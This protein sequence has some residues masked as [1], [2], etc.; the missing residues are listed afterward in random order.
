MTLLVGAS[1]LAATGAYSQGA[2][3]VT[4]NGSM[5][6][7]VTDNFSRGTAT[8]AYFLNANNGS[9]YELQFSG[10][11]PANLD[12]YQP[13]IVTGW[14]DGNTLSVDTLVPDPDNVVMPP[15]DDWRKVLILLVDLQDARASDSYPRQQIEGL[16]YTNPRSVA[17]LF[18]QASLGRVDFSTGSNF[19]AVTIPYSTADCNYRAW[20]QAAEAAARQAGIIVNDYRHRLFVLPPETFPACSWTGAATLGC[21][22]QCRAWIAAGDQPIVYVHELG[23]NLNL[24]HAGTDLDNNG[25]IDSLDDLSDPMSLSFAPGWRS[26]N[27]PHVHQ[28]GWYAQYFNSI[29]SVA[30]SG[31]YIL[32]ALDPNAMNS[33]PGLP[34]MLKLAKPGTEDYYYLSYRRPTGYDTD[35]LETY[36]QGVNIN[37]YRGHGNSATALVGTLTDGNAAMLTDTSGGSI[38]V[39]QTGHSSDHDQVTVNVSLCTSVPPSVTLSPSS[40][41]VRPGGTGG[42]SV[43]V[44]N[45]DSPD[46]PATTFA[47]TYSGSPTG[48]ITPGSLNLNSRGGGNS[49]NLE[50]NAPAGLSSGIYPIEVQISD[51]DNVPP[52]HPV[53]RKLSG[54]FIV[55]GDPP[56]IPSG[57]S[58]FGNAQ[59]RTILLIWNASTDTLAGVQNYIIRRNNIE[60]GRTAGSN[61]T[62]STAPPGQSVYTVAA[63]D[64]AGNE[65]APS[66]PITLTW[67]TAPVVTITAP[68]DGTTVTTDQSI[69]FTGTATDAQDGNLTAGLSWTSSIDGTIGNGGA[70][71]RTLSAG[72]HTIQAQVLDSN[73][74]TNTATLTL[75]VATTVTFTS[76]GGE[77]GWVLESSETSNIGGSSRASD[78]TNKGLLLGDNN[79]N[80]QYKSILSFDTSA[81]P[82]NATIL[83]ATLRLQ[84]GAISGTN[85]FQTHGNLLADIK[86]GA[87]HNDPMLENVDFQSPATAV[88]V[89]TLSN[90]AFNGAWSEGAIDAN[91]LAAIDKSGRTQFRLYFSLDDNNDR[92]EDLLGY[93]AGKCGTASSRPQLVV[94]YR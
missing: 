78:N 46:C 5:E 43:G 47:L 14:L 15:P 21:G 80:R 19:V 2:G 28:M 24:N 16:M 20:A 55:D 9:T 1:L 50:V 48:T 7:L 87:F 94:I 88:G 56:T 86:N 75:Y 68:T 37:W 85:P 38:Q 18:S 82:D 22:Y 83:S 4:V 39:T 74:A 30:Q 29:V 63:I 53:S 33:S 93:Y 40:R 6:I 17:G 79:N 84:R 60:I 69:T 73:G 23:H 92:D 61:F 10:N 59:N 25:V 36:T 8:T 49:A 13:V 72:V 32:A 58:G 66:T 65:S 52:G 41:A 57:L 31:T 77:D 67:N 91:G 70:F 62:D 12:I 34:R 26:F 45:L 3:P 27:G 90:A 11:P 51:A 89:A 81:L 76:I 71:S 54:T 64:A 35:L 42:Y 44:T